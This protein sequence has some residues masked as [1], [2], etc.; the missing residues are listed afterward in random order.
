MVLGNAKRAIHLT[1]KNILQ[2]WGLYQTYKN[3]NFPTQLQIFQ[4]LNAF[5]TKTLEALNRK[6]NIVEHEF[7][8]IDI[9]EVEELVEIA[10]M[11]LLIAYPF[12][13]YSVV[14]CYVGTLNDDK[15]YDWRVD[16]D[17]GEINIFLIE[18]A[19][20]AETEIGLVFYDFGKLAKNQLYKN[21]KITKSN[22]ADWLCYLDLLIYLTRRKVTTLEKQVFPGSNYNLSSIR[23]SLAFELN[24]E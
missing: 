4:E 24:D 15:C 3:E 16:S 1:I 23:Q 12:L 19:K 11:F 22:S 6:R 7:T 10:E 9:S 8:T 17:I 20:Y 14:G 13:K 21:I 5:P 2:A 18:D